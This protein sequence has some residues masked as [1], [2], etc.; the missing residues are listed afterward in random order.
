MAE[1]KEVDAISRKIFEASTT[2]SYDSYRLL[3]MWISVAQL[4][5]LVLPLKEVKQLKFVYIK[6]YL[7]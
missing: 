3:A 1:E 7:Y 4:P 2:K 5:Q 6:I